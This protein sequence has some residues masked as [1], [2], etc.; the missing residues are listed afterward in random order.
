MESIGHELNQILKRVANIDLNSMLPIAPLRIMSEASIILLIL[1]RGYLTENFFGEFDAFLTKYSCFTRLDDSERYKLYN[2]EKMM[3]C[4]N[5][6]FTKKKLKGNFIALAASST[7][8]DTMTY[9]T[10]GASN[11]RTKCREIIF[12]AVTKIPIIP[13]P[14]R[15]IETRPELY[16]IDSTNGITRRE[17]K[18]MQKLQKLKIC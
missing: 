3:R 12:H 7:E 9:N 4:V 5:V 1:S 17:E 13:R 15:S 10:G 2:F 16:G 14:R 18:L 8:G 11:I 6:V